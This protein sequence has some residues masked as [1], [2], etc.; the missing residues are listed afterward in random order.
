[1]KSGVTSGYG[2]VGA[3]VL[4]DVPAGNV[5]NVPSSATLIRL[6]PE[7]IA[8]SSIIASIGV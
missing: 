4:A 5:P 6:S 2:S 1:M 7:I 8:H 3:P